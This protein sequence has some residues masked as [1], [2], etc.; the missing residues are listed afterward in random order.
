MPTAD[1]V[2][3]LKDVS[4][5][6]FVVEYAQHLKKT[7]KMEVPKW[8]DLAK[9]GPFKELAPYDED[10]AEQSEHTIPQQ[11]SGASRLRL[12]LHAQAR[13]AK[14]LHVTLPRVGL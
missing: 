14:E 11:R 9:T 8:V 3:T 13:V 6:D 1:K 7:G 12:A 4:S 5:H 10:F 2:Y